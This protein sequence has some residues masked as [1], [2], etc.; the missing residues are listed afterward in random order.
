ML[1]SS[2]FVNRA[3]GL[4]ARFALALIVGCGGAEPDVASEPAL[5]TWTLTE[6]LRLGSEDEGPE[7]FGF[8]GGIETDSAGHILVFDRSTQAIRV[9]D[10][11]GTVQATISRQGS[12]PGELRNALGIILA[13]NGE[14]WARDP[15]NGRISMFDPDGISTGAWSLSF[16]YSGRPWAPLVDSRNRI[17][18][19]DCIVRGGKTV[20][21][22]MLAYRTDRSGVDT[23]GVVPKCGSEVLMEAGTWVIGTESRPSYVPVPFAARSVREL[24]PGGHLWCVENSAAYAIT[25]LPVDGTDTVRIVRDEPPEL[26]TPADR[27]SVIAMVETA[28]REALDYSRIPAVKPLIE[29][30]IVDDRQRLWVQRNRSDGHIRFDVYSDGGEP[31][32]TA[33]LGVYR[34]A[35][36]YPLRIRGDQ[37][38]MVTTNE[39]DEPRVVRFQITR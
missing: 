4:C 30:L 2:F 24:A 3:G 8:I 36:F 35:I 32:A 28:A 11:E 22:V 13:G 38:L 26:V 33:D 10:A 12:G 19:I 20:G 5:P 21:E 25:K 16:C 29:R 17:L 1:A 15:G 27:D 31:L 6:T 18:D 37:L 9:F 14:L 34:T 7:L 23:L 39:L